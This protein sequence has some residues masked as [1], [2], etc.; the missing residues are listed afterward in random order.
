MPPPRM[1]VDILAVMSGAM[2]VARYQ[3]T[4]VET[5]A[6]A[7]RDDSV[8]ADDSRAE[9]R[10]IVPE[11]NPLAPIFA[12]VLRCNGP[13]TCSQRVHGGV[14]TAGRTLIRAFGT[15]SLD[16][17]PHAGSGC[18]VVER[19]ALWSTADRMLAIIVYSQGMVFRFFRL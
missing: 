14:V 13:G 6:R 11:N 1:T 8:S 4:R 10:F 12:Q 7:R 3:G 18:C 9:L 15:L 5:S 16:T 19:N 2:T 17:D